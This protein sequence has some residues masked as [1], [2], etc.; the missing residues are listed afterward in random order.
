MIMTTCRRVRTSSLQPA[1]SLAQGC[2][3]VAERRERARAAGLAAAALAALCAVTNASAQ[4]DFKLIKV[5]E[6][7]RKLEQQVY[8]LN[9]DVDELKK[10]LGQG[11][12]TAPRTSRTPAPAPSTQWIN[13]ASWDRVRTGMEELQVIDI[14]G[15][16]TQMRVEGATRTL[17]YAVEIGSSGFLSGSVTLED[18]KVARVERPGL[19]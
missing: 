4:D 11:T 3:D 9:R 16:P 19:K 17:L 12:T 8:E 15:P 14:L 10:R 18:K 7:V 5:E 13:A 1:A 2:A 6:D